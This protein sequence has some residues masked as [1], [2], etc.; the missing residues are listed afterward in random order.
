MSLSE[1]SRNKTDIAT[2]QLYRD[3]LD[4]I[5]ALPDDQK[6]LVIN[7]LLQVYDDYAQRDKPRDKLPDLTQPPYSIPPALYRFAIRL[8]GNAF[9]DISDYWYKCAVNSENRKKRNAR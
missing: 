7:A 8:V 1:K 6:T 4:R 3:D 9:N 5:N 2:I